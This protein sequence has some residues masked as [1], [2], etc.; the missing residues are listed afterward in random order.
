MKKWVICLLLLSLCLSG[1]AKPA[2][3]VQMYLLT[4]IVVYRDGAA[5]P[6][7][8]LTCR[9]NENGLLLERQ[10][11]GIVD[12]YYY[13]KKGNLE[14]RIQSH[15][16]GL[17]A[18]LN[19][20]GNALSVE[21]EDTQRQCTYDARGSLLTE[22]LTTDGVI[23]RNDRYSYVYTRYGDVEQS[24]LTDMYGQVQQWN[25]RYTYDE[26]GRKLTEELLQADGAP[27]I[28]NYSYNENG[29]ILKKENISPTGYRETL[30]CTYDQEGRLLRRSY[31]LSNYTDTVEY[32]YDDQGRRITER[33]LQDEVQMG[34]R[35]WTYD[36]ATGYIKSCVY[37]DIRGEQIHQEYDAGGRLVAIT[38][39]PERTEFCYEAVT[40]PAAFVQ[41]VEAEQKM[42]IDNYL[43]R[44]VS[45]VD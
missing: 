27:Y 10:E 44:D 17:V 14:Y 7:K 2:E 8:P 39:K 35:E 24:T 29:D 16:D 11:P 18:T 15:D 20:D 41:R 9:Y 31:E 22:T 30:Y 45:I 33:H 38:D 43:N 23:E 26:Q 13:D 37:T 32:T 12:Q 5:K 40:V 3:P 19:A 4:E 34:I 6:T 1:C 28:T 25:Y 42:L 36:D 21:F